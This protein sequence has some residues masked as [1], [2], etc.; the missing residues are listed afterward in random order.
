MAP[1]LIAPPL[2]APQLIAPQLIAPQR[3]V[4][5]FQE[6]DG[7]LDEQLLG[8]LVVVTKT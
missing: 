8:L 4:A 2:I 5:P 1:Q 3:S 7:A 6:G